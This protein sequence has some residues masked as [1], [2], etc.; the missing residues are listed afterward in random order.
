MT[1]HS[2]TPA[3]NEKGLRHCST[4]VLVSAICSTPA[5]N[6]KGLRLYLLPSFQHLQRSTPALNEK[7]LRLFGTSRVL[8][9]VK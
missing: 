7:G 4:D 9:Q 5:L 1:P 2:S 3:L 6:E 8:C